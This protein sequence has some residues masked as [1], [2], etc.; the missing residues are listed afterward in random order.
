MPQTQSFLHFIAQRRQQCN[1][2]WMRF[3]LFTCTWCV[4]CSAMPPASNTSITLIEVTPLQSDQQSSWRRQSHMSLYILHITDELPSFK[5]ST[6]LMHPALNQDS[7]FKWVQISP[8]PSPSPSSTLQG[9]D[10]SIFY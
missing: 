9:N 2:N 6:R 1:Q 10:T 5:I 4:R 3:V 8:Q 7:R